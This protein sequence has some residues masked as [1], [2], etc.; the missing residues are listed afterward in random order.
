MHA[1][2]FSSSNKVIV[3]LST[4]NHLRKNG[5]GE[6]KHFDEYIEGFFTNG[7]KDGFTVTYGKDK[8][9]TKE[10]IHRRGILIREKNIG[11]GLA[12]YRE[13]E[14]FF[15]GSKYYTYTSGSSCYNVDA[16][17]EILRCCGIILA[18]LTHNVTTIQ[19]YS[20][21]IDGNGDVK[22][23]TFKYL[24]NGNVTNVN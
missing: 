8:I 3:D 17:E 2:P 23:D 9:I 15:D 18:R 4:I 13:S 14:S 6:F 7:L 1:N 22:I 20:R 21:K 5:Y 16:Y 11:N 19:R 12:V 24:M 10:S